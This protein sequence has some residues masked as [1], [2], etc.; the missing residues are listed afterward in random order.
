MG[1]LYTMKLQDIINEM[2]GKGPKKGSAEEMVE[3]LKL[4]PVSDT[5][6]V[7]AAQIYDDVSKYY[8][9]D[10]RPTDKT[11]HYTTEEKCIEPYSVE[12][13]FRPS[14]NGT[15]LGYAE[16][17][18]IQV[19]YL[20]KDSR[21]YRLNPR[22]DNRLLKWLYNII[23]HECSHFYLR[24]KD[25]PA[26]LYHTHEKGMK[27]YYEDPQEIALHSREIFDTFEENFPNWREM[28]LDT[29]IK[30]LTFRIKDLP[31]HTSIGAPFGGGIQK[32]YLNHI[33]N[34]YIKPELNG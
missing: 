3:L 32:K 18:Y 4:F 22:L 30:R 33:L 8:S 21:E 28:D 1:Y 14:N 34:T 12:I 5:A 24:Q 13:D 25:V 17:Q 23:K 31:R 11:Y 19:K 15:G 7:L 20:D 26:C 10:V 6:M 9:D 16:E 29:I 27:K 2:A